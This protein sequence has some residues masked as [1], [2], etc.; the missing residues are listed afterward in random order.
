L[1]VT[2]GLNGA[3]LHHGFSVVDSCGVGAAAVS[4]E[5]DGSAMDTG[6]VV[7][8]AVVGFGEFLGAFRAEFTVVWVTIA[9]GDVGVTAGPAVDADIVGAACC[10]VGPGLP[11][12][13]GTLLGSAEAAGTPISI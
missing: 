7:V 4:V 2:H 1:A 9:A 5:V 13:P 12:A 8:G 3:V 11:G 10:D 6:A